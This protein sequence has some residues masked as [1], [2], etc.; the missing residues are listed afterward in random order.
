MFPFTKANTSQDFLKKEAIM[1]S[2]TTLVML[3]VLVAVVASI[4]AAGG[5]FW[6]DGGEPFDFMTLRAL[7]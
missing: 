4:A 1:K 6:Q 3:S 5:L 7:C 2:S